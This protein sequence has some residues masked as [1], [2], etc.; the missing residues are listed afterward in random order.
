M[1]SRIDSGRWIMRFRTVLVAAAAIAA[2]SGTASATTTINEQHGATVTF[3]SFGGFIYGMIDSISLPPS[4]TVD[5]SYSFSGVDDEFNW[6]INDGGVGS[7]TSTGD[8]FLLSIALDY[9]SREVSLAG[10]LGELQISPTS[11]GSITFDFPYS[12]F[13][14]P[15]PSTWAMMLAGLGLVGW[16]MRR[17]ISIGTARAV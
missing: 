2:W 1:L 5:Y 9:P 6:P 15:E 12:S 10:H 11:G 3:G 17:R 13:G 14:L 8:I 4:G 7:A 16:G